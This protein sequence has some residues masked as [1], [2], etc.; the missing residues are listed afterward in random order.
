MCSGASYSQHGLRI[1]SVVALPTLGSLL[2]M[3]RLR[4][5]AGPPQPVWISSPS[6]LGAPQ[7]LR[8]TNQFLIDAITHRPFALLV[9]SCLVQVEVKVLVAQW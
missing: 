9:N 7:S 3:Q 4:S 6:D 1:S 8:R 2:G 5:T